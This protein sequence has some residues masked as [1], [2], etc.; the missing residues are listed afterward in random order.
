MRTR[1]APSHVFVVCVGWSRDGS[2]VLL[3]RRRY[4]QLCRH[5]RTS[6]VLA[7]SQVKSAGEVGMDL[8][9]DGLENP[10]RVPPNLEPGQTPALRGDRVYRAVVDA[11]STR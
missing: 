6:I 4:E 1:S 9:V 3:P 2:W 11:S 10:G 7:P 5:A 8:A